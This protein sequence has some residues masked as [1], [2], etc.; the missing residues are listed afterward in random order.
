MLFIQGARDTFG[1]EEEIRALVKRLKL[2]AT[3]HIV[4]G[5]DHSLKAPKSAGL[6]QPQ[7]YENAMDEIANWL[8]QL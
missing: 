2:P 6:P 3:L 1:T 7:V 5:G 4:T 8:K